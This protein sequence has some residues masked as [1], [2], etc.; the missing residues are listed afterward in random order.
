MSAKRTFRELLEIDIPE[1]KRQH[2]LHLSPERGKIYVAKTGEHIPY[3]KDVDVIN[4]GFYSKGFGEL[5]QYNLLDEK[6]VR[7]INAWNFSKWFKFVEQQT[8]SLKD[9]SGWRW[10]HPSEN[11]ENKDYGIPNDKYF[12]WREK[13]MKSPHMIMYPNGFK[14]SNYNSCFLV[15]TT[16]SDD[17][18]FCVDPVT[19]VPYKKLSLS[20][21][22][23]QI[24]C[25][26]YTQSCVTHP[27]F[28]ELQAILNSGRSIVIIEPQGPVMSYFLNT[29]LADKFELENCMR[30]DDKMTIQI[31]LA[32]HA[33]F[34]SHGFAIAALLHDP[35]GSWFNEI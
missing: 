10:F 20:E 35:S 9:S 12:L 1:A 14:Y 34:F 11:H 30:I 25:K 19:K 15:E 28:I 23:R 21:A 5:S 3:R 18:I 32:H 4:I 22:R 29:P 17:N 6:G 8:Q 31:L 27:K 13:G 16:P 2:S 24:F 26:S 7:I 33:N